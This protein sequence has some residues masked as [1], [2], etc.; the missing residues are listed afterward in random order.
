MSPIPASSGTTI[1]HRLNRGGNRQL[2]RALFTIAMVQ[3]QWDGQGSAY[4]ARKRAEGKTPPEARRCL[5]RHLAGV[6]YRA[7]VADAQVR[8]TTHMSGAA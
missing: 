7:M 4:L 8:N 6:A 2:N 3:A 1:R 5:M